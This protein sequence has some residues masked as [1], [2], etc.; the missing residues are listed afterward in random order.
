MSRSDSPYFTLRTLA[1]IAGGLLV[2]ALFTMTA[3]GFLVVGVFGFFLNGWVLYAFLRY[4][5]SRQDELYQVIRAAIDR[6]VPLG[7]AIES[8]LRDRPRIRYSRFIQLCRQIGLVAV[9][10]FILPAFAFC[11]FFIGWRSFD[12]LVEQFA[13][14]LEMGESLS[15]A[16]QAVPSVACR[17]VRLAAEVGEQTGAL[18]ACLKGADRERWSAAWLEVAP[19]LLY[20]FL[21]F[22][23]VCS[24]VAFLMIFIVPK[25]Q[26][27]FRE[28]G[29]HLPI[30]TST[31]IHYWVLISEYDFVVFLPLGLLVMGLVMVALYPGVRWYTPFLGRLY[32]WGVQ[33]E[34]LRTLGRLL[35]AGQTVPK[36]LGFLAHSSVLPR[37]VTKR[38]NAATADVEAGQPLNV[39]LNRAGLLPA[40]MSALLQTSERVGSLPW[41]L[42]ELGDHQA[43]RA[44][45]VV[46]RLSLA[47]SPVLI[48]AVGSLVGFVVLAM[49]LPLIQLI[50]RLSE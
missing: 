42:I 46:R 27:I 14:E 37:V 10:I 35:A 38:L 20:P 40:P 8:Y 39:S 34:I 29:E 5:E 43:A 12:R 36:A 44:F 30:L 31:M 3:G 24:I 25:Y 17:E 2:L 41:A 19:R 32:R 21:V 45:R 4:R 16:Y 15:Q 22:L 49:F 6:Q 13:E 9:Y 28:F 33:G 48:V 11:R 1:K 7:P 26:R 47:V 18:S 23:I 50:T